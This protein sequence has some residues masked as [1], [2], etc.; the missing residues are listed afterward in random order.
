M[1]AS[2]CELLG[3]TSRLGALG[4]LGH[5][6][7]PSGRTLGLRIHLLLWAKHPTTG[8]KDGSGVYG[9]LKFLGTNTGGRMEHVERAM[10]AYAVLKN[11]L[12]SPDLYEGLMVFFRPVTSSLAGRRFIP[13]DLAT[14]LA[15]RYALHIPILVLESLA[16]RMNNAGL[17]TKRAEREGVASYEYVACDSVGTGAS[18][19]KITDL[20]A[21]FREF[22]RRQSTELHE[23]SD[24]GLDDA[25][26]DRL[27]RI[28]SLEI[29]SRRDGLE[30]PKHTAKTL[31]LRKKELAPA[32]DQSPMDR[33][34][35]Y[36]VP[37][38][39]L[40]LMQADAEGFDLLSDIASANLAAETLLTYRDPPRRGDALDEFDLY[41]DAPLCLDILG[42]NPGREEYGQQLSEE[43]KRAGC[44]VSVFLHSIGEIERVLDARKQSYF[45]GI[46]PFDQFQVDPPR[47]RDLVIALAGHAEQVLIE[48]FGFGVID[49]TAAIPAGRRSSVGPEEE[50]AIREQLIGW[51]NAEGREVDIATCCDLI[52]MRSGADI[53]TRILKAGATLATRNAVL[54]RAA[55]VTWRTWLNG[56]TKGSRDR[57]KSAAPLAILDKQLVGLLWITQGG[58]AG[59]RAV[60]EEHIW[61]RTVRLQ[62]GHAGMSLLG[63]TTPSWRHRS[64]RQ[65]FLLL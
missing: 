53:Q 25:L 28:E 31:T 51:R 60:S 34:L 38:F 56:K 35:D 16:E 57:I 15:A 17:I 62:L 2:R 45:S 4:S 18:L 39:I 13:S 9:M 42:V 5:G 65:G 32:K 43:L 7:N 12:A 36:V 23:L 24:S 41:L 8:G 50:K 11:Q 26:F 1:H 54:A 22:A 33:H 21:R 10:I 61:L 3:P 40:S 48:Q 19:P 58:Q 29:L 14:E 64:S 30:S 20:L 37:R 47:T 44:R 55:N 59:R 27:V 63:S 6:M 46:K 52:R 49:S